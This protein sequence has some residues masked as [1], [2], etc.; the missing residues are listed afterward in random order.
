MTFLVKA[1]FVWA[2]KVKK[3]QKYSLLTDQWGNK[4]QIKKQLGGVV[5]HH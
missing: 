3:I 2:L 4:K 5:V 1:N